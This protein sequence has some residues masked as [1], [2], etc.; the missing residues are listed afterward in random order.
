MAD[1]EVVFVRVWAEKWSKI[2]VPQQ[3]SS[4]GAVRR[5][6]VGSLLGKTI[7][8]NAEAGGKLI[9]GIFAD[10]RSVLSDGTA[11]WSSSPGMISIFYPKM[12]SQAADLTHSVICSTIERRIRDEIVVPA[13]AAA[14]VAAQG[15]NHGAA[16][17][18]GGFPAHR[19]P[20]Q[21]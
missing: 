13:R 2:A 1:D 15:D 3:F 20:R 9:D 16:G 21:G 18:L 4:P 7:P 8:T 12:L 11:F 5:L 17:E 6:N 10:L 19:P 14:G